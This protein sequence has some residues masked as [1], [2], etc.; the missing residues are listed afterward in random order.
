MQAIGKNSDGNDQQMA[1]MTI[2][3][4]G[5]QLLLKYAESSLASFST[6]VVGVNF[7]TQTTQQGVVNPKDILLTGRPVSVVITTDL[8]TNSSG[9]GF[10]ARL[11][12]QDN[13]GTTYEF[14]SDSTNPGDGNLD[15]GNFGT[16]ASAMIHTLKLGVIGKAGMDWAISDVR[17]FN[18]YMGGVTTTQTGPQALI[19]HLHGV[20]DSNV[21]TDSSPDM[22]WEVAENSDY[23]NIN[24][25]VGNTS[26]GTSTANNRTLRPPTFDVMLSPANDPDPTII[27]NRADYA[28]VIVDYFH[29]GSEAEFANKKLDDPLNWHHFNKLR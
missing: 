28:P 24:I 17:F 8:K 21:F 4:Q 12:L 29:L 1:Q 2:F 13:N 26:G 23:Q 15:A 5:L 25:M 7:L 18:Q 9:V 14:I 20:I 27:K 11:Y 6:K 10:N 19:D 3:N 22:L 16:S